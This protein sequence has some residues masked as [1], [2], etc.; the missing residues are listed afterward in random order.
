MRIYNFVDLKV[1]SASDII[2]VLSHRVP[3]SFKELTDS[4]RQKMSLFKESVDVLGIT[5]NFVS[6]I[7]TGRHLSGDSC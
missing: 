3:F 1:I 2:K 6:D 7:K 4:E 5:E